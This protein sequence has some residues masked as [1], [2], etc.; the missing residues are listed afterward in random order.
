MA[1]HEDAG[2]MTGHI[3]TNTPRFVPPRWDDCPLT[4]LKPGCANSGLELVEARPLFAILR[5]CYKA[6]KPQNPEN[7]KKIQNPP[8]RVGPPKIRKKYI[9]DTKTARNCRFGAVFVFF[10]YFSVFSGANPG[11]GILCFFRI[12]GILGFSGL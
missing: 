10:R 5:A 1:G 3:G 12:F 7:T 6:R 11:W 8:P 2:V 4:L 9:K